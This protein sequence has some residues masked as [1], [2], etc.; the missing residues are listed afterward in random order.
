MNS[1]Q[2]SNR[3]HTLHNSGLGHYFR[4]RAI[5]KLN[6]DA[7]QEKALDEFQSVFGRHRTHVAENLKDTRAAISGLFSSS[8]FDRPQAVQILGSVNLV[9]ASDVEGLV[10]SFGNFYDQLDESQKKLLREKWLNHRRC[11]KLF[12]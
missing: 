7:H 2:C 11:N 3:K 6:L 1:C 8:T 12:H 9:T 10:N 4:S 5:R